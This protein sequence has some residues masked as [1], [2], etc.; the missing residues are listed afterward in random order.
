MI[1]VI[2]VDNILIIVRLLALIKEAAEVISRAFKIRALSE[3]YYYLGIRIIRN[4]AKR[5]LIVVQDRYIDKIAKKFNLV[6]DS[7]GAPLSKVIADALIAIPNGYNT[8]NALKTE[9]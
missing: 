9:Y 7:I 4:K 1:L 6:G 8:T 3:L 2:Y 5:Q